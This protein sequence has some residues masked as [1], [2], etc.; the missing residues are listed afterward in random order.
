MI[1]YIVSATLA[2][3]LAY[4]CWGESAE[5]MMKTAEFE[6]LQRNHEHARQLYER[7][8]KEHPESGE[9]KQAAE[10]LSALE[11]AE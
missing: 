9:A 11:T 3:L 8:I 7:I 5:Q 6:E 1:R 4:G 2:A 10:R